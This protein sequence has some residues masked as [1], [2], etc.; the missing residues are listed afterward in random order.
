MIKKEDKR[1]DRLQTFSRRQILG[2]NTKQT[3]KGL[4]KEKPMDQIYYPVIPMS[5]TFGIFV[6]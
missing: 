4:I 2:K 3:K 6:Y 5:F 1:N